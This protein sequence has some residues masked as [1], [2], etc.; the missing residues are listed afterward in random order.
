[1]RDLNNISEIEL[2]LMTDE[3]FEE[4]YMNSLDMDEVKKRLTEEYNKETS[5]TGSDFI[6][7]LF[8]YGS[9]GYV[10]ISMF[11]KFFYVLLNYMVALIF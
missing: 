10:F 9:L 3:E 11:S 5:S 8:V 1:M 2:E 7:S 6:M 4:L